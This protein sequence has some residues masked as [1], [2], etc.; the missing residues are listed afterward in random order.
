MS[1]TQENLRRAFAGESM[2]RN[3]YTFFAM[4]AR[5]EGY[6]G[7]ARIFEETAANEMEHAEREQSFMEGE[8]ATNLENFS[9]PPV[10]STAENLEAAAAGEKWEWNE[11]YPGFEKI[12]REEGEDKIADMFREIGEVEEQHEKRYRI[13]IEKV[14]AKAVFKTEKPIR[15]KCLNCGYI[16]EGTEPP[17]KCPACNEPRAFYEPWCQNY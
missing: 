4:K 11:M 6:E 5:K 3:K 16:H 9:V 17:A 10:G 8:P 1:K 2:A 13:L 15:W 14:K 7:I 12:A